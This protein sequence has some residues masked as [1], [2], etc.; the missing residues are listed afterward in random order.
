MAFSGW[1]ITG[2]SWSAL[3]SVKMLPLF[4]LQIGSILLA[5]IGESPLKPKTNGQTPPKP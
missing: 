1:A 3:L 4:I 2:E 5:W